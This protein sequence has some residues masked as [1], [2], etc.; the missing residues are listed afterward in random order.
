MISSAE[1][2]DVNVLQAG[3]KKSSVLESQLA[4][5]CKT[6]VCCFNSHSSHVCFLL[7][8]IWMKQHLSPLESSTERSAYV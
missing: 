1:Q 3:Q 6:V 2:Q 5:I 4:F 8:F 7:K